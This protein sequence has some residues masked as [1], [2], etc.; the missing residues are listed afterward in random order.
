MDSLKKYLSYD[1]Y[2]IIYDPSTKVFDVFFDGEKI[3]SDMSVRAI[4]NPE[5]TVCGIEDF[6]EC[7]Y[8]YSRNRLKASATL[9]LTYSGCE[10]THWLK[11][12]FTCSNEGITLEART[13]ENYT[14]TFSGNMLPTLP[15]SKDVFPV[16]INRCA[17]EIRASIGKSSTSVD[18]AIYNR[19]T[20]RAIIIGHQKQTK[21]C[22]DKES[23][24]FSFILA[25]TPPG[26]NQFSQIAVKEN[27]L[28]DKYSIDF[29]PVNKSGVFAK[30]PAGWMTWYAVKFN[31]S[32]EKVLKN[33]RMQA[34]LLKDYGADTIWVDWEWYHKD[35]NGSRDDGVS[36]LSPD[37]NKYPNGLKFVSE[38]I[39]ESGF[40]PA[41]W[42]G[43]TNEPSINE[44][45]KDNPEIILD[46]TTEWCG[47]Y[48]LDFSHPKYLN[49]YLPMVLGNV[50]KWG[51]SAVKYDTIPSALKC[52]EINH[53]KM[54]DPSISTKDAY[55]NMIKKTREIL[56]N[57][58]YMLSCAGCTD[59]DILW[60]SDY[61]DAARIG[62]DIFLWDEFI[63]NCIK[64]VMRYYPLHNIQLYNDPDNVV[65]RSEFNSY[66][67][68]KSRICFVSLL[69]LPLT[70]G[71]EFDALDD[72]RI[73]LL[74]RCL[75]VMDIHPSDLCPCSFNGKDLLINLS[76]ST[77]YEEY[78]V[79]GVFNLSSEKCSRT[80]DINAD[81]H[82]EKDEYLIYDYFADSF[83]GRADSSF[84]VNLDSHECKVLSIRKRSSRPQIIST[85]RHITQGAAEIKN[86]IFGD[87]SLRLVS[88]LV[89]SDLYTVTMYV[90][91]GYS[92]K[93]YSGFDSYHF[94]DNILRLCFLPP[95]TADYNF[96][97]EFINV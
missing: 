84:S 77:P 55:K 67:Q 13:M 35:F 29:S 93:T 20:D 11:V 44:Y 54:Y 17:N 63:D 49:E 79:A 51:Y 60:A 8:A 62:D 71:D 82:L 36:A 39:K 16:C 59:A 28:A 70:I 64:K 34:Q 30:P 21:L 4:S 57:D 15:F 69:G 9:T 43:Y 88:S 74:R 33:A 53:M 83:I 96:S 76:V 32:E 92:I 78:L 10:K 56:G 31:A 47:K 95:E 50:K 19:Q 68:A 75:P 42:I 6:C 89:K 24:M 22:Y 85:S 58:M 1:K 97:V 25:I 87:N 91:D 2:S 61:F 80:L 65:L 12:I 18:N 3:I 81:F 46:D 72:D 90:P 37:K 41:L 45:L 7:E 14:V 66:E 94:E 38:K 48:F 5:S 73:N 26:Y 27:I 23:G 40:V 52:H 86:F